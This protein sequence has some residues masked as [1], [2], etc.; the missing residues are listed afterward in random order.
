MLLDFFNKYFNYDHY[1]NTSLSNPPIVLMYHGTPN[2]HPIS[3]YSIKSRLFLKHLR[4]LK[5][6]NKQTFLFKDILFNDYFPNNS[7][8]ITFDDGYADNFEGAVT[9]LLDYGMKAT[10]FITTACIGKHAQ[11][12]GENSSENR[13]LTID[14]LR[15]MSAAGLEIASHTHSH[16]DLSTLSYSKQYREI[17]KSKDLLENLLHKE[18]ISF[19]YP[20]GKFNNDSIDA[21]KK[22]NFKLACTTRPGRL[23]VNIEHFLIPRITIFNT[24]SVS[25]LAR[26]LAFFDNNVSWSRISKYYIKQI[27]TRVL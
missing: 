21:I 6:K 14:Q 12:L 26:K 9:H 23:S 16:P 10:W 20:Y 15:V 8:I 7:I 22:S 11:W 1:F 25:I 4:Y 24:D 3:K 18:I 5:K 2:N 13:M 17:S 19:A 27:K